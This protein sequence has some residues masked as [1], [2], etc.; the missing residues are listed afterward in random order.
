VRAVQD[1]EETLNEASE[2][3][4]VSADKVPETARRFFEEWKERGKTI[5]EL[6]SELAEERADEVEETQIEGVPVVIQR[7]DGDIDE[8]RAA[9]NSIVEQGKVAI[10]GSGSESDAQIVVA[11]P[12]D[13]NLNAGDIATQLAQ[14]L[15]GG[16][17]GPPDFGQ[18][19]GPKVSKLDE[20]LDESVGLIKE[21]L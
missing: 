18:G 13:I 12:E 11:V 3:L 17:G 6:K 14:R 4:G 8:L 16:G 2:I 10:L 9:A 1:M 19:G 21:A 15:G 7:L 5:E 20:V